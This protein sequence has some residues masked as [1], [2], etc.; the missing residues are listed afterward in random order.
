MKEYQL[1]YQIRGAIYDTYNALGPGLLESVYEEALVYF[2]RKRGL[3]VERQVQVPL[4][5]DGNFLETQLRIDLLVERRV[6]IEIKSVLDMRDVF[7]LQLLTY[8]KL[9]KLHRGILVNFNTDNIEESIW[10]KVNGYNTNAILPTSII[11]KGNL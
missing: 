1:T 3:L 9:T 11:P 2:L 4:I 5:V 6:I 7:H 8:L 10:V